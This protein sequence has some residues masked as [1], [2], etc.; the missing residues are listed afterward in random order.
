MNKVAQWKDL[1]TIEQ[2]D[3]IVQASHVKPVVL[4]KHSTRCGI[5]GM[6]LNRLQKDW[7]DT[8]MEN[9]DFYYLDLISYRNISNKIAEQLNVTHQSPQVIILKNGEVVY[10]D[11]HNGIS[12]N[13]LK[14][15]L[16]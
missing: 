3:Q 4:F 10:H 7:N 13:T 8:E 16:I 1:N 12:Y 15:H 14:S 6:V 11:S 9:I 5:S 2:L